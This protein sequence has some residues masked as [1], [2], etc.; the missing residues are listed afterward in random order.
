MTGKAGQFFGIVIKTKA[1]GH[2]PGFLCR[3]FRSHNIY[4][5]AG[6]PFGWLTE[7]GVHMWTDFV[8]NT[9]LKPGL[10]RLGTIGAVMLLAGGDWLCQNWQAC[11]LVT[12]SGAQQVATYVVAAG[13][14]AF[15]VVVIH[16]QRRNA[17]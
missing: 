6:N 3:G 13:M 9:V 2:E 1:V 16:I 4:I 8:K 14:L 5:R 17:K 10:N 15:D 12:A 7:R 11:G